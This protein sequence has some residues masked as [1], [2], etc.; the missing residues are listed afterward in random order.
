VPVTIKDLF[1]TKGCRRYRRTAFA[2]V[3]LPQATV[4]L[5]QHIATG[6]GA[7]D[8]E[9]IEVGFIPLYTA[10]PSGFV[11]LRKY[12]ASKLKKRYP[13]WKYQQAVAHNKKVIGLGTDVGSLGICYRTDLF[14]KAGL[15]TKPAALGKLWGKSWSDFL[16]VGKRYQ[17]HAPA[18]TKFIDSGSNLFNAIVAQASP[19]ANT[20]FRGEP[21]TRCQADGTSAASHDAALRRDG[22]S[23]PFK[24][25]ASA[26]D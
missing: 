13:N 16:A 11:D 25:G 22:Q 2:R 20:A 6:A 24:R 5:A 7:A 10:N 21:P 26:R 3:Q 14:K 18:G 4:Q 12:G 15:P 1:L 17:K 19:A 9:A 23:A 8:V